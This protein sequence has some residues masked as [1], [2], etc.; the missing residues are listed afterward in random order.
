MR[1]E[2]LLRRQHIRDAQVLRGLLRMVR[3]TVKHRK[4]EITVGPAYERLPF[5]RKQFLRSSEILY[6]FKSRIGIAYGIVI[7]L[8]RVLVALVLGINHVIPVGI[9][10]LEAGEV[11]VILPLIVDI[12]GSHIRT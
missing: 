1:V 7:L 12:V 3:Q 2:C 8:P 4:A 10:V 11:R 5:G 9:L 6:G